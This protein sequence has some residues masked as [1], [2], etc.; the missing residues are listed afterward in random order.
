MLFSRRSKSSKKPACLTRL[1]VVEDDVIIAFAHEVDL[2]HAGYDVVATVNTGEAAVAVLAEREI[3]AVVLD[4]NIAG[5]I[6]GQ[7]VARLAHDRG[8]AVL[9]VSGLEA[10]AAAPY[11]FGLLRKPVGPG[12]LIAALR[13]MEAKLCRGEVPPPVA[14]LSMLNEVNG[15]EQAVG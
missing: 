12:I 5:A 1:L 13:A 14:G 3:D 8:V 15:P 10:G 9:L 2:K 4:L 6:G 7:D 11:A